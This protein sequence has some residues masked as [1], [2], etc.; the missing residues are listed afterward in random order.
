MIEIFHDL[1][2]TSIIGAFLV[3]IICGVVGVFIVLKN[4]SFLTDGVA[5]GSLL[6]VAIGL[7]FLNQPIV[8]ALVVAIFMA[9]LITV[10]KLKTSVKSD[11]AIGIVYPLFFSVGLILMN[12]GGIEHHEL[13]TFMFGDL[14]A[15]AFFDLI[16]LVVTSFSVVGML[17]CFY[18]DLVLTT[19]DVEFA[20]LSG[21][22]TD[23][24]EVISRVFVAVV[25]VLCIKVVGVVLVTSMFVI[26]VVSSRQMSS[27]FK[28]VI[29]LS[30]LHNFVSVILA[31]LLSFVVP[32]NAFGAFIVVSSVFLF[33]VGIVLF[34]R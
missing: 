22:N 10:L 9:I 23:L 16:L 26:P 5:H 3:A 33:A 28:N 15:V 32:G 30:I 14:H 27:K 1:P 24:I 31:L 21:I 29:L 12:L 4:E 34:S 17:L 13:E 18:R 2:L 6:G 20:K 11:A 8:F 25:I 19:F 7:I